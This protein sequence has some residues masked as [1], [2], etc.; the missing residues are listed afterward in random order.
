MKHIFFLLINGLLLTATY[1][2][3][4]QLGADVCAEGKVRYFGK[5]FQTGQASGRQLAPTVQ[6]IGD[7][8]IDV[9]YYGLDLRV[10]TSP[11]YLRGVNNVTLKAN[12]ATLSQF[13]LDFNTSMKVDSVKS[14]L[15]KL[16]YTHQ[17]NRLTITLPQTITKGQTGRVTVYYQGLPVTPNA[18]LTDQ[19]FVFSTHET[20]SDPLIYTLSEPYGASDWFPCKDTPA[21]KVDSSAVNITMAPFFVSV[22]NGLLQGV[23]TNSDG[24]KTYR[25]KNSYPIAQY[26]ISI[27]CSNYTLYDNPLTYQGVTM[28]VSHYVFPED[29][30]SV[31]TALTET[32][33]MITVFSDL[34]GT[35]PFIREK[36]GHAQ[37]RWGGGM[38]HQTATSIIKSAMTRTTISHELMHQWFGDKITCRNWQ[39]IWLNEGF[40]SYGEAIYQEA[41]GGSASYRSYMGSFISRARAASGTLYVQNV[42]DINQIFDSN[43]TYSKGAVVLHMLRGVL[44]DTD[45][46]K[47]MKAYASSPSAYS[48]AVTEDFQKVMETASGKNLGYFFREWFY[49]EGYPIYSYSVAP[50]AGTNRAVVRL[51]QTATSSNPASFT[52]PVQITVQSSAGDST[53]TVFNDQSVQSFTVTGK[54]TVTNVV[55]DPNTWI[56]RGTTVTQTTAPVEPVV[57]ATEEAIQ[58]RVFPNPGN[59]LL[60]AEFTTQT[61]G[62]LT[63]SLVNL[64]GQPVSTQADSNVPAGKQVRTL[65][66]KSLPAGRYVL[67]L[68]TADGPK[69]TAVLVK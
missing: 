52:M 57:L 45:F 61:A 36:Y 53:I 19:A 30:A 43:R 69:S 28:P 11:N 23:T 25:W 12:S 39:N 8:T 48:T 17:S 4:D 14:G 35:Y 26:L 62:P 40:A 49:G 1:A 10:T 51:S 29:L 42:A 66:L 5:L 68:Q 38:E 63:V 7:S 9:T 33:N 27:A 15:Q 34:F 22:S 24:T 37:F 3:T 46:F 58:L 50:V 54:G 67:R 65:S 55:I 32:N 2:Q 60:T 31:K 18:S 20:T 41:L 6:A 59:E 56:L 44:G 47:G 64:L 21:D 16:T 13:Y